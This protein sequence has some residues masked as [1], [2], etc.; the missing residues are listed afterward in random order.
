MDIFEDIS[1]AGTGT[2]TG[3]KSKNKHKQN[4]FP[5]TQQTKILYFE[6]F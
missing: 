5:S 2:G 6:R 3:K 1:N 4:K